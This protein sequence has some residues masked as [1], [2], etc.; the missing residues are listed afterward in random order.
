M[1]TARQIQLLHLLQAEQTY[2]PVRYYADRLS[3][4]KRTLDSEIGNLRAY[5]LRI[6]SRRGV[7]ILLDKASQFKEKDI[8]QTSNVFERH[9][10]IL[11]ELL[12]STEATSF[13]MLAEKY[14]VSKSSIKQDLREIE[15]I[16]ARGSELKLVSDNE[17][18][19][20]EGSI[21]S[22][23]DALTLF[24]QIIMDTKDFE[25]YSVD[26]KIEVLHFY[27]PPEMVATCK[28]VFYSYLKRHVDTFSE[29]YVENFLCVLIALMWQLM[30]GLHMPEAKCLA[31]LQ[32]HAFFIDS[33]EEILRRATTRL[34]CSYTSSD[35][36][37]LSKKLVQFRLEPLPEALADADRATELIREVARVLN[38][39]I[40]KDEVLLAQIEQHIPAMFQ[41]LKAHIRIKN[42]FIEQIKTEYAI[43]FNSLWLV[44][45]DFGSVHEVS[46]NDEEIGYL[47]IYFQL[48][49]E[50]IGI[51][52]TI[53]V[54]CPAGMVTSELLVNRIER[55]IPSF[56]T[57]EVASTLE[58]ANLNLDYYDVILSTVPMVGERVQ[59]ISPFIKDDDLI[60]LLAQSKARRSL[61]Q[62][63]SV[64]RHFIAPE[65]VFVDEHFDTAETLLREIAH[66]LEVQ[67]YVSS[68]F[69]ESMIAREHLGHTDMPTGVAFPHGS[70]EEVFRSFVA[71]IRNRPKF[72]WSDYYVDIIFIIGIN[73]RDIHH[74]KAL[75]SDMYQIIDNPDSLKRLRNEEDRLEVVRQLYG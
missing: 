23:I 65:W 48:A 70:V 8:D 36:I 54:V 37:F 44:L 17:G 43:L 40:T 45:S 49:L 34:H 68:K 14:F 32:E 30:R 47:T 60:K 57:L 4:S 75:I 31:D 25:T 52:R 19:R 50:K 39:D 56:D 55:V 11:G 61:P 35:V 5:G 46:F 62:T 71:V 3:V 28:S 2:Q 18:T 16:I 27:Y 63:H 1:L 7:G 64:L 22:W 13:N 41:R 6:E 53:L 66:R 26:K 72:K 10:V 12:F 24:N 69:A 15:R 67:G 51:S 21:R 29:M 20:L 73:R 9:I 42:P 59:V 74:T 58:C 38:I 33:A